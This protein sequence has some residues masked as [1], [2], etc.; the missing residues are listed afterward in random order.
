MN[1]QDFKQFNY[2]LKNISNEFNDQLIVVRKIL[3]NVINSQKNLYINLLKII[4][5]II[6]K[7][8][9]KVEEILIF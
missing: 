5:L 4:V 6:I 2:Y 9:L 1:I 3:L 8:I 7:K